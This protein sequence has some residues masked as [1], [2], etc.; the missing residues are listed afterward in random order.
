MRSPESWTIYPGVE[1]AH[2]N[3]LLFR[4][5]VG[6]KKK[7]VDGALADRAGAIE[8]RPAKRPA[9]CGGTAGPDALGA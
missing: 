9:I 2:E 6:L 1:H 3:Q 7:R 8:G 5:L 4:R